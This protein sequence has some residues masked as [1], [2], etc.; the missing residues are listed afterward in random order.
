MNRFSLISIGCSFLPVVVQ[1]VYN[2]LYTNSMRQLFYIDIESMIQT[3][4][5]TIVLTV[6][7]SVKSKKIRTYQALQLKAKYQSRLADNSFLSNATAKSK[8]TMLGLELVNNEEDMKKLE[9]IMRKYME[10]KN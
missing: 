6:D 7:I 10:I 9:F 1:N 4:F 3:F 8:C 2:L 5:F